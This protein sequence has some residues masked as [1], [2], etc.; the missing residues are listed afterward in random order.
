[1][2]EIEHVAAHYNDPIPDLKDKQ[3]FIVDFSY[4]TDVLIPA[5]KDAVSVTIIDHHD[6]AIEDW[7]NYL[8]NN[9]KPNNLTLVF[10]KEC[11]GAMRCR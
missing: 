1:M 5:L 3:V 7:D 11:S 8:L 2:D 4:K 9:P 10:S 6:T